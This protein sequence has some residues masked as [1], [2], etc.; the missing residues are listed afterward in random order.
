[1]MQS[2]LERIKF[3][4]RFVP[5]FVEI[6]K[7]LQDMI[8]KD[9]EIKWRSKEKES[10]TKIKEAIVSALTLMSLDFERGFI[11]Y[12]FAYNN[13]Y[14]AV[15]TQKNNNDEDHPVAFMSSGFEWVELK[16]PPVYK[17]AF[18]IFKLVKHFQ[19]FIL[20]S[21]TRVIVPYPTVRNLLV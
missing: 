4:K 16:Y 2:F 11:L 17:Q 19:P 3:V 10:F 13:S 21:H 20:K 15:L 18:S 8:K 6:V 7:P 9:V 5:S 1:M 14:V 12:T